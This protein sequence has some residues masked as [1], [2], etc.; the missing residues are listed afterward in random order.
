M[1]L[2][3]AIVSCSPCL[4]L[5]ASALP[6][7]A[8]PAFPGAEGWG[9]ETPGGRGETVI[10][11]TNL[12]DDGPGSLRDALNTEGPRM[13]LFRV[14][15][16]IRLKS[17][18]HL[19][20]TEPTDGDNP[21]SYVTVAGHSAPGG[22]ITIADYPFVIGHGVHDVVLRHLRFRNARKSDG[23]GFLRGSRRVVMDHCSVSWA[24]DENFG[25]LGD[26]KEITVQNCIVAEGLHHGEHREGPHSKGMLVSR[27]AHHVAIHH[28]YLVSNVDRNPHL[29]GNNEPDRHQYGIMHPVFD[30]R[31][32]L[33]YNCK[34]GTNLKYGA[35]ANIV[36]NVYVAGP[37]T[38]PDRPPIRFVAADRGD[39][40]Y[41]EANIGPGLAEGDQW[42]LVRIGRS[43]EELT[44]EARAAARVDTPFE[45]PPVTTLAT[46]QVTDHVLAIAGAL[47]HDA[48]DLRLVAEFRTKKGSCGALDR[49]H[50]SPIPAPAPGEPAADADGDG[51]PDAWERAH[52]LDP[53]GSKD[54][55]ADRD[56]D[57]YTNLEEYLN[58][59]AER[60]EKEARARQ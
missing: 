49:T 42:S 51:M 37:D 35:R 4:L 3:K 40:A 30:V 29:V 6:I 47:P 11:V 2:T 15:G 13:I 59:I 36:G 50:D 21:Y 57:G 54:A 12:N 34:I 46:D 10:L 17:P 22:G 55:H 56:G 48:T 24:T 1:H 52:G 14:S 44:E 23:I 18:I 39:R 7:R 27:G 19:G 5:L 28:C 53:Q 9:T 43:N 41:L 16:I 38:P 58:A 32:N 33:V 26:N 31:N 45:A 60:L 20:G 8:L 25:F